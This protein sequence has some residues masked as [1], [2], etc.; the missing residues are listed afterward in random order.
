M[1][2]TRIL[3]LRRLIVAGAMLACAGVAGAAEITV[4]DTSVANGS[5]ALQVIQGQVLNL[6][7]YG[8]ISW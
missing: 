3:G 5:L 7:V 6:D 4:G 8:L 1:R 2:G